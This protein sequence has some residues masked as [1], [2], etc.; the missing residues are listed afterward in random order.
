MLTGLKGH[1]KHNQWRPLNIER[2]VNMR[3]RPSKITVI[4]CAFPWFIG[5]IFVTGC[6]PDR[7]HSTVLPEKKFCIID[8]SG[9][10]FLKPGESIGQHS[11]KQHEELLVFL[12]GHGLALIGENQPYKIGKGKI[13]YIPPETLHNMKNTGT[14]PLIYIYCVAPVCGLH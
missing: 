6:A 4:T 13:A 2:K 1:T 11:T 12:S 14:E 10:V 9:R 3:M 5:I 8:R 7:K